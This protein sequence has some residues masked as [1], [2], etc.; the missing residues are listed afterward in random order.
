M[1]RYL[2]VAPTV[3]N[4]KKLQV[5][6]EDVEKQ[7]KTAREYETKSNSTETLHSYF[8]PLMARLENNKK[9]YSQN[10]AIIKR[11]L[12]RVMVKRSAV[13][14][15]KLITPVQQRPVVS[16]TNAKKQAI[17][18]DVN[19]QVIQSTPLPNSVP[20]PQVPSNNAQKQVP[21]NFV[22]THVIPP[23]NPGPLPNSVPRPQ[24]PANKIQKQIPTKVINTQAISSTNPQNP[25]IK[26]AEVEEAKLVEKFLTSKGVDVKNALV[27]E[28]AIEKDLK[29]ASN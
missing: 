23:A 9:A 21:T 2:Q 28:H 15:A 20:R 14:P 12:D 11:T 16:T 26:K 17:T 29:N 7:L 10:I 3:E 19:T 1:E 6:L 5:K 22:Y 4:L 25:T 24:V 8:N 27:L 18:K 13:N